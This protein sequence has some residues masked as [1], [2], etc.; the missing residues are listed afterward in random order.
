MGVKK[1]IRWMKEFDDRVDMFALIAREGPLKVRKIKD[2]LNFDDWWPVKYHIKALCEKDLV[3][4]IEEGYHV[5]ENGNKVFESLRTV[6]D[7]ESI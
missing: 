4:E 3:E 1:D 2:I 5:T 7:I 6:S